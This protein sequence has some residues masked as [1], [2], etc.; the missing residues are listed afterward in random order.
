MVLKQL[1]DADSV[2][3]GLRV[4]S[5]SRL[6]SRLATALAL[7]DGLDEETIQ[8]A[9]LTREQLNSTALGYGVA[10]PHAAIPG[11]KRSAACFMRLERRLP[12]GAP[13]GE[14]VDLVCALIVPD[15]FT[16]QKLL[17]LAEVAERLGSATRRQALRSA[18]DAQAVYAELVRA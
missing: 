12:M 15:T 11:L 1:L 17:L 10:L 18:P 8:L 4:S 13:D 6:L 14:P 2:Y 5:V 9:L 16:D 7:P 3:V